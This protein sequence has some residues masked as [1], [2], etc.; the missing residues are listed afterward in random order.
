MS[1]VAEE[2]PVGVNIDLLE[3]LDEIDTI[4]EEVKDYAQEFGLPRFAYAA[5]H[6]IDP[7]AILN[8]LVQD[9][10]I[11]YRL[12]EDTVT[13]MVHSGAMYC[14]LTRAI[15]RTAELAMAPEVEDGQ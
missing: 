10:K 14:M 11:R 15:D 6:F 4:R 2:A 1:V 3:V 7:H 9:L 13:H 12:G 5:E 8:A